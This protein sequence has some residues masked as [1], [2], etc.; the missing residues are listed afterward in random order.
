[1]TRRREF[2]CVLAGMLW[3]PA[4]G[5]AQAQPPRRRKRVAVCEQ[6]PLNA[7]QSSAAKQGYAKEFARHG[8]VD[9]V[10]IEI[11][12]LVPKAVGL[13]AYVETFRQAVA[14]PADIIVGHMTGPAA[15]KF[16]LPLVGNVP[17]VLFGNDDGTQDS[18]EMLNR[19]GEN[20]TGA[21]YYFVEMV[22]KR[23]ELVK[24]MR[25]GAKRAALVVPQAVLPQDVLELEKRYAEDRYG[26]GTKGL[27]LEFAYIEVPQDITAE[28]L[29]RVLLAARI[30]MAEI[31]AYWPGRE[32]WAPLAASGI[33]ASGVGAAKARAGALLTG[34]SYGWFQSA[35]RLAARVVRGQRAADLPVEH[36]T[37]F[38]FYVNLSTARTLGITVP[39]SILVRA[40]D[41]F[42]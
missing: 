4:A 36:S 5:I 19:R 3:L 14:L 32:F 12:M 8:L 1:M 30:D 34:Y 41:V 17:L 2:V 10:D 35:I 7:M 42:E 9:G 31:S 39:P 37:E 16:V 40:R 27:G 15:K 11:I 20:V 13:E 38:W 18:I 6:L 23:F 33:A 24:E 21:M 25:P 22:L 26:A 29:V 28:A